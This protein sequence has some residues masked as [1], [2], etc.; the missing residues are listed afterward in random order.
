[1]SPRPTTK[2]KLLTAVF[3]RLEDFLIP[4]LCIVCDGALDGGDR[5]FCHNCLDGL[6]A[7]HASRD[8]CPRCSQNR[9]NHECGCEFVWDFPFE[10]VFSVY[11]YDDTLKAVARH[12]KYRGKKRLAY[13]IGGIAA[14]LVPLDFFAGVDVVIPVPLHKLRQRKRGYN[15]AEVF[16]SG[17]L[18]GL[19][20]GVDVGSNSNNNVDGNGSNG[21]DVSD[22]NVDGNIAKTGINCKLRTD[23]LLRV[24][25]TG[26]QTKLDRD[27]RLENLS[28]AFVVNPNNIEELKGKMVMLVDDIFTT[29]ATVE[30]CTNV[31]LRAG[32]SAVRVLSLGRGS[33]P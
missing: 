10:K 20:V 28:G 9:L 15:Q 26:T 23:L 24:K 2:N 29:G 4:P 21:T 25:N 27:S 11:D 1:M 13:H 7:N 33:T 5:W 3:R 17:L 16:A 18:D 6:A 31:L 12:I 30:A 32:C 22:S 19:R 8:A 14:P